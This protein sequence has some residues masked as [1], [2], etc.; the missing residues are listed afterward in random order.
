MIGRA[1][2]LCAGLLPA[3]GVADEVSSFAQ[4]QDLAPSSVQSAFR[5]LTPDT[6]ALQLDEFANPGSLW[7]EQGRALFEGGAKRCADC[8]AASGPRSLVGAAVRYPRIEA[9]ADVRGLVN[10]EG[11]INQCRER[12]QGL[13]PWPY[14]SEALLA[15]T[16]Y[17][18]SLSR[19]LPYDVRI[20]G[21]AEPYF[22]RGRDY[23]F[24]RKG[25]LNLACT[26]CHD[27]HWGKRLRGDTLSQGHPN[28]FPAYR[29]EWQGVGSLHRRLQDC[30][31]GIRAQPQTLGGTL[32]TSVEL[33][34]AWRAAQLPLETPGV[35]R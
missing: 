21:P 12:Q 9:A 5:Y 23:F 3:L 32:Y 26:Q 18:A 34:L 35:R 29:L 30:D 19:G 22:R 14:E 20:D 33:Y 28:A 27:E 24:R 2:A 13:A 25:Q 11:R 10:L 6:Q 4:R 17:V 31:R 8:H 16:A 7:V 15:I 1:L